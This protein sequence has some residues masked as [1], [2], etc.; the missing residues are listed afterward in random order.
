MLYMTRP[1]F[2]KMKQ[3]CAYIERNISHKKEQSSG[4]GYNMDGP[5]KR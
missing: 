5:G 3:L 1:Q 2:L 4:I